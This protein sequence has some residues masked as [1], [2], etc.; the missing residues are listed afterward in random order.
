M[1]KFVDNFRQWLELSGRVL[2]LALVHRCLIDAFFTKPFYK[3]I[4]G[5]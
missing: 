3:L 1:S 2:G 4:L 5:L